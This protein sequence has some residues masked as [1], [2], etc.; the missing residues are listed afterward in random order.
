MTATLPAVVTNTDAA[1]KVERVG[2]AIARLGLVVT[3]GWIGAMKFTVAEAQGIESLISNSPLMSWLLDLFDLRSVSAGIGVIE[4]VTAVLIAL[5]AWRPILGVVGGILAIGTFLTTLS[6]LV[7]S[8]TYE[9]T[10][11]FFSPGGSFIIKD[12]VLL[13]AAVLIFAIRNAGK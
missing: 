11:P 10:L 4:V 5:G 13:G 6:F 3:I 12:V 8:T 9:H 2:F 7:T 1:R